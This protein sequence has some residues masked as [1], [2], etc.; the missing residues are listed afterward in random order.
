MLR[1]EHDS[2]QTAFATN[3]PFNEY[4]IDHCRNKI[5]HFRNFKE[6]V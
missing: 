4:F 1:G 2:V 5:I 3:L 6:Q